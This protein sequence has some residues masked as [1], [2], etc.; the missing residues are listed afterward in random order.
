M[1][2]RLIKHARCIKVVQGNKLSK[3]R[4]LVGEID[5]ERYEDKMKSENTS[6]EVR[7]YS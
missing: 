3:N 5:Y 2:A 7:L 4:L 1:S 6:K